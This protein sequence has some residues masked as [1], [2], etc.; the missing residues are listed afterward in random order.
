MS[1]QNSRLMKLQKDYRPM[2][3]N[4]K[5]LPALRLAGN[6]L[7]NCGFYAGEM[8]IVTYEQER[9]V[10]TTK[11]PAQEYLNEIKAEKLLKEQ[12]RAKYAAQEIY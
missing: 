9:L 2:G 5:I 3:S 10:I 8:V 6:L 1:D 4:F 11:R 7:E 12:E